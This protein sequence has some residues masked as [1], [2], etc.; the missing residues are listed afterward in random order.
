VTA[1]ARTGAG[2][3]EVELRWDAAGGA[4][5]YRVL[6][7][8]AAGPFEVVVDVS[9]TTGATTADDDVTNL[10]SAQHTYIPA[11]GALDRP[12]TSASFEYVDVGGP[13]ERCYR[14][15]AY[16]AFGDG[17]PSAVTCGSPP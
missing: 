5:G 7:S 12:D 11:G 10:W 15:V 2:S 13:G 17:A 6:R 14:V 16:N 8:L 9:I 1:A 4:T 3:T